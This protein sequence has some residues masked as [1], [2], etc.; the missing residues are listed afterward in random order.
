[1]GLSTAYISWDAPQMLSKRFPCQTVP[2]LSR[3]F[4]FFHS[5]MD[6]LAFV[7]GHSIFLPGWNTIWI[8]IN[9]KHFKKKKKTKKVDIAE[10]PWRFDLFAGTF[11]LKPLTKMSQE[12]ARK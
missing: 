8:Q 12:E 4:D 11:I 1:M 6:E 9:N 10:L 3:G 7:G 5:L 2:E